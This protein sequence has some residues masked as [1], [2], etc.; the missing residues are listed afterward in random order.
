[1][2]GEVIEHYKDP[3]VFSTCNIVCGTLEEVAEALPSSSG[4][5]IIDRALAT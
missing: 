3:F 1:M 2:L 5:T 4:L